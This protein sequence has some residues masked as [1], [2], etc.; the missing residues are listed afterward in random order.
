MVGTPS[1]NSINLR[2]GELLDTLDCSFLE[3]RTLYSKPHSIVRMNPFT[4]H[5]G[6]PN[7]ELFDR[8]YFVI[9]VDHQSN[10]PLADHAANEAF[11]KIH[12]S[13]TYETQ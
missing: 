7:V 2:K 11:G 10:D 9:L 3:V 6:M 1:N 8:V 4:I 12:I 5:R 13:R